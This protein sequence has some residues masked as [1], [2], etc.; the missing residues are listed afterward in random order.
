MT[1]ATVKR[2]TNAPDERDASTEESARDKPPRSWRKWLWLC[3]PILL[4]L[5]IWMTPVIVAHTALREQVVPFVLPAFEGSVT[6]ESASFDWL[7]PVVFHDLV[8]R[9]K[10]GERFLKVATIATERRLVDLVFDTAHAGRVNIEQPELKVLLRKDGSNIEDVLAALWSNDDAATGGPECEVII[11]G[12]TV[13]VIDLET[14]RHTILD[15]LSLHLQMPREPATPFQL[16][17]SATFNDSS[18]PGQVSAELSWNCAGADKSSA[19]GSGTL[20]L[21]ASNIPLEILRPLMARFRPDIEIAGILNADL[22]TEWDS[23]Q[24]DLSCSASGTMTAKQLTVNAPGYLGSDRLRFASLSTGGR[25]ELRDNS[26]TLEGVTLD[27]DIGKLKTS[28]TLDTAVLVGDELRPWWLA[29]LSEKSYELSGELDL[30]RI[31]ALLPETLR[32]R[33]GTQI[34]G[35][36]VNLSL[37]SSLQGLRHYW[38]ADLATAGL[39]ASDN[40]QVIT[41]QQPINVAMSVYQDQ[42]GP[43]VEKLTCTSDFLRLSAK[44]TLERSQLTARCNLNRLAT[45]LGRF[46]D[47]SDLQMGGELIAECD[48]ERQEANSI[49]VKGRLLAEGFEWSPADQLPWREDRLDVS[50]STRAALDGNEIQH[51]E[52]SR[53]RVTS[54]GDELDAEQL[55]PV[56]LSDGVP[57]IPVHLKLKGNLASWLSRVQPWL[58]LGDLDVEGQIELESDVIASSDVASVN[59]GRLEFANLHFRHDDL[60]INEPKLSVKMSGS[61][62]RNSRELTSKLIEVRSATVAAR[63]VGVAA[64]FH[65]EELPRLS[66]VLAVRA[67]LSRLERWLHTPNTLP[68]QRFAGIAVGK[69]RVSHSDGVS[70]GDGS[71]NIEKLQIARQTPAF[72]RLDRF[73][74]P[75]ATPGPGLG[76]QTFFEEGPLSLTTRASYNHAQDTLSLDDLQ[77]TSN[78]IQL[79]SQGEAKD[80]KGRCWVDLTGE[81]EYD[82]PQLIERFRSTLG[83]EVQLTGRL[84]RSFALSGPLRATPQNPPSPEQPASSWPVELKGH[85]GI[86]WTSAD[87]YGLSTGAADVVAQLQEGILSFGQVELAVTEGRVKLAPRILLNR[88]PSVMIHD[89]G[90]VIENVRFSPELCATWLKYLAPTFADAARI[91]GRFS[92][93][94]NGATVPLANPSSG[95]VAGQLHI[96]S[97]RVDSGPLADQFLSVARQV[98]GIVRKGSVSSTAQGDQTLLVME[99]HSVDYRM[100]NGRVHHRGLT[101]SVDDVVIRTSGSV[102]F[103]ESLSL[104]AEIPIRD[105]WVRNDKFLAGLSGQVLK[106]PIT[107]TTKQPQVDSRVLSDLVRRIAGSAANRFIQDKLG[108]QLEGLFRFKK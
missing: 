8:A 77:L 74:R 18:Q 78:S 69:F 88:S 43:V 92:L 29:A 61:Y 82:L 44:G 100:V 32:I 36:T 90:T 99:E 4:G 26:L 9:D 3:S 95:D 46:V 27:S 57:D 15:E 101:F 93:D 65:P 81:A 55:G 71:I 108:K 98:A 53:M 103:D 80:L 86:G 22:E 28:G 79:R 5:L 21:A 16:N 41:W 102:G 89:K 20:S 52:N 54:G 38:T 105:E 83:D 96:H 33:E 104:T 42:A 30:A 73:G 14:Y 24:D 19:A 56:Q 51:L 63:A 25:V 49:A 62:D 17:V 11:A 23:N 12:G 58:P 75:T 76:W 106:I 35:G 50:I 37:A 6:I 48:W 70:Q 67:N 7:S 13:E 1:M 97:A 47:L 10:R 31:A 68:A 34:T 45:E 72:D 2:P 85:A 66:G 107:G 64:Q 59:I 39:A 40:G 84:A 87:V 94:V 60:F 91:E